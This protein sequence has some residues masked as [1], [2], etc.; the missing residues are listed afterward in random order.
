[1]TWAPRN[2]RSVCGT[3]SKTHDHS[4]AVVHLSF[5]G[6]R[7]PLDRF[8]FLSDPLADQGNSFRPGRDG[9]G[10]LDGNDALDP[11][12]PEAPGGD[13]ASGKFLVWGG[14]SFGRRISARASDGPG[15]FG[16]PAAG[17]AHDPR[18]TL[19]CR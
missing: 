19:V 6:G 9:A 3:E 7:Y 8:C 2:G 17:P 13:L 1:M 11:A 10:G 15:A 14:G 5:T 18:S 12:F 4:N 16:Q